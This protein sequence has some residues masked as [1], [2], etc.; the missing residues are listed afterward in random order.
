MSLD[1]KMNAEGNGIRDALLAGVQLGSMEVKEIQG[2][3]AVM[4]PEGMQV[5]L[6]PELMPSPGRLSQKITTDTAQDFIEYFNNFSTEDSVIFCNTERGEFTGVIDYHAENKRPGWC[7][8][9]VTHRCKTTKEWDA[10][11]ANN[12][13]KMTQVDFAYFIEQNLDEIASPPSA[14]M[15]EIVL[16]LKSQTKVHFDSGQRL[17]D[18]QVQLRYHEEIESGAGPKGELK[19][20][21]TIGIGVRVFEGGDAFSV[22]ARFRY[23]MSEGKV[24]MWYDL[25]RPE[26]VRDTALEDVYRLFSSKADASMILR[27]SI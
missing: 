23:R 8:H 11:N 22:T 20:P 9:R 21:E 2:V 3:P 7:E 12:G 10:W 4:V 27:G 18:G 25:V 26:K 14:Q 13:K 1:N 19:I 5:A 17:T 24:H 6:Y 16:T 15:L